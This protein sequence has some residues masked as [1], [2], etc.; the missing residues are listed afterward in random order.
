MWTSE[1]LKLRSVSAESD[2]RELA[3]DA[4]EITAE[5]KKD[6]SLSAL[7]QSG[8]G[9][10]TE[11]IFHLSSPNFSCPFSFVVLR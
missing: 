6:H 7:V 11:A 8:M 4:R 9:T 3:N 10:A 2:D 5:P 1:A